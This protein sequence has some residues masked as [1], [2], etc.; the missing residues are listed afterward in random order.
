MC[1]TDE[2][3]EE[4]REWLSGWWEKHKEIWEAEKKKRR[5]G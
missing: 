3:R 5:K 4:E 1:A 2:G